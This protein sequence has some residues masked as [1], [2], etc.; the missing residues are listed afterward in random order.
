MT[1]DLGPV[2]TATAPGKLILAGEHAVVYG[3]P[4]IAVPLREHNA[5][6]VIRPAPSGAGCRISAPQIELDAPLTAL[7]DDN[8]LA[9]IVQLVLARAGIAHE[10]DLLVEVT[11]TIPIAGG[12][13]SGAAI[14]TALARALLIHLNQSSPPAL[15]SEMVYESERI[16]HGT[17]SGIDNTV[18][19]YEM[20]VYFVKGEP[21][22]RFAVQ[23]PVTLVIGDSGE[24]GYTREAVAYVRHGWEREPQRIEGLFQ[25]IENVVL[26]IRKTLERADEG[27]LGAL[28]NENQRLL[29]ELGV[30]SSRLDSLID[31]ARRHGASGAKLSGAGWGGNMIALTTPEQAPIVAR[32]LLD[33]VARTTFTT[34]LDIEHPTN[35]RR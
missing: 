6:A 4:A 22:E 15:I 28:L 26:R 9:L 33:A 16:H 31:A 19:A 21:P 2:T 29:R 20:P 14:S 10:P 13:G 7:P 27:Q 3:R 23:R 5:T 1:T 32:A 11:S 35:Y 12:L 30:S 17:P 34:T 24:S 8:P 18:I 25:A